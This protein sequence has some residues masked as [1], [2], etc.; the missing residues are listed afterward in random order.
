MLNGEEELVCEVFEDGMQ[1]EHMTEYKYLG[2][3]LNKSG[4]DKAVSGY[5]MSIGYYEE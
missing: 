5:I 3:V 1:L 4:T 2:C